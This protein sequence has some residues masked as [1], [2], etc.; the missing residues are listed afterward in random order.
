M[1]EL[2]KG[3]VVSVE[4]PRPGLARLSVRVGSTLTPAYALAPLDGLIASGDE[5]LLNVTAETLRLG[6]RE[7]SPVV[8]NLSRPEIT[9]QD[10]RNE[11]KLRYTAAQVAVGAT[12][13][14]TRTD[15]V[16]LA[17]APVVVA[18]LHSALAPVLAG[19]HA[20]AGQ[21]LKVGYVMPDWNA[22]P[23]ALSDTV[24]Q[25]RGEGLLH[26]TATCG[27]AFGGDIEAAGLPAGLALC[28]EAGADALVVIGG[29]GH[30]GA[31]QPFGF[32]GCAQSEALHTAVALGGLPIFCPRLSE[33]DSRER[34]LGVSHHTRAILERLLLTAVTVAAPANAP[35]RLREEL[36]LLAARTG[37]RVRT[38]E[39]PDYAS[40]CARHGMALTTMG[41]GPD[42]DR[43]YFDAAAAAGVL[44]AHAH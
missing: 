33:G 18:E 36:E 23:L 9:G 5:V 22:L 3:Q 10:L 35:E 12:R 13:S 29:P 30:L 38:A 11:M 32:S 15:A 24:A 4:R 6:T 40:V 2:R 14:E 43:L 34:H 21:A 1:L 27:H 7:G 20:D 19:L 8:A 28:R 25:A 42:A 31:R 44:A 17:G 16:D 26:V 39:V 37:S 41:R